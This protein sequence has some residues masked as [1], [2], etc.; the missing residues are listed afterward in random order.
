MATRVN[1]GTKRAEEMIHDYKRRHPK[2]ETLY[3]VYG[4]CSQAKVESWEKIKRECE[5]LG[6]VN[7]HITGAGSHQYSCIYMYP[8][9][10][11]KGKVEGYTIRKE[12]VGNTFELELTIEEYL[13]E[14]KS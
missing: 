6:G 14:V 3:Q 4:S 9:K 13:R 1:M 5:E 12:T 7:L 11:D 10:N 8:R 2:G